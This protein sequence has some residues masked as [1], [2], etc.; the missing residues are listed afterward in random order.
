[1]RFVAVR[2]V[3]LLVAM[4]GAVNFLTAL[5]PEAGIAHVARTLDGAAPGRMQA[6]V[7]GLVLLAV[8]RGLVIGRR[9]AW[10]G[11]V[12]TLALVAATTM[13]H[14]H[15]QMLLAATALVALVTLRSDFATSPDPVRLRLAG[16]I[17]AVAIAATLIGGGWDAVAHRDAPG[18]VGHAVVSNV[19]TGTPGTWGA[20]MLTATIAAT[21]V[22]AMLVALAPA[23]APGPA[24]AN[25]RAYVRRLTRDADAD[26]LA[27]FATRADKAYVFGDDLR[28]AIGYRVVLG[29]AIAG[30]DPVGAAAGAPAAMRAFL[31]LCTAHGWRPA[32]LGAS[33]EMATLWRGLGLHGMHIGDEAVLMVD[34]FSLESRSMRNVRQAVNR[35][36]NAGVRVTIAPLTD[37][38][39]ALLRPVL[40]DWLS[41]RRER[42]FAM[43]L[44][45]ILTPRPDCLVTTAYNAEGVPVAFARFAKCADGTVL[46]LDVAPRGAAAPNG[47]AERMI[48]EMVDYAREHGAREVSL[49]FA[50]LRWVFDSPGIA[51][52]LAAT[53]LRALDRW[54][55]IAPL[56]R[57][58]AKFHPHWRARSLM[59]R[60]FAEIGWVAAAALRVE[61]GGA[62]ASEPVPVAVVDLP[63]HPAA[64]ES[65]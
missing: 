9:V 43:N 58:C 57:F 17:S 59:M 31:D 15:P 63:P 60:S 41:G 7:V 21:I 37:A 46:T 45:A 12:A 54:I 52:R 61:L 5:R 22:L 51:A 6:M 24:G 44:D 55:E 34:T 48:V 30:G 14:R 26:S 1:M 2:L 19:S 64:G 23:R 3:A 50:A 40:T 29:T 13:P 18:G 11:G 25:V 42:G 47:V 27:P 36:R 35:T 62:G 38:H 10:F 4:I 53:G 32:V 16:Q 20:A 33:N 65:A 28:T 56:N 49:N 8:A 39:A